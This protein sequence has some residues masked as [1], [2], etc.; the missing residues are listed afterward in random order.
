MWW[1]TVTHRSGSPVPY[2]LPQ[3]MAY[4]ALLPLMRTPWLPEVDWTDAPADLNGLVHFAE[5]R[6][7]VSA[8][9][10][11]HFN[12]PL[13]HSSWT[14]VPISQTIWYHIPCYS[15]LQ[16]TTLT[17]SYM[18]IKTTTTNAQYLELTGTL[19]SI[20]CNNIIFEEFMGEWEGQIVYFNRRYIP[21]LPVP[22][23][24]NVFTWS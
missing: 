15:Y 19:R 24:A 5:R 9:V 7:L 6:K 20:F 21:I 13:P 1:H 23:S 18:L 10:P 22:L 14:L 11:S 3:N 2:T 17:A 8:H 4:P 16:S 12:W